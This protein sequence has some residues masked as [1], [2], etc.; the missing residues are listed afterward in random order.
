MTKYE[1]MEYKFLTLLKNSSSEGYF[2]K[3]HLME[4]DYGV[5][6]RYAREKLIQWANEGLISLDVYT[7]NG[8]CSYTEWQNADDFFEEGNKAGHV[9]VRLLAAGDEHLERLRELEDKKVGF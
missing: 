4:R 7:P 3:P 9:R 1:H 6:T 5:E 2:I 8:F